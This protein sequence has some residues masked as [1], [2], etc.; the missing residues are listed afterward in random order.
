M[1]WNEMANVEQ[2][3]ELRRGRK[4]FT[5]LKLFRM[6]KEGNKIDGSNLNATWSS[7][8]TT[9]RVSS[10]GV[11]YPQIYHLFTNLVIGL[12]PLE[13][14]D[15]IGSP[16]NIT[17]C[18][19]S[20]SLYPPPPEPVHRYQACSGLCSPTIWSFRSME[21]E[22]ERGKLRRKSRHKY[23]RASCLCS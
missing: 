7:Q 14:E 12:A 6:S 8:Q 16:S 2:G 21:E 18:V 17:W 23:H 9:R 11:V 5:V 20:C 19:P 15:N 1:K 13:A 3:Q 10:L 22:M 4:D